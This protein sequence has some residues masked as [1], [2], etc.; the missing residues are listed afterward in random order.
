[1]HACGF[2]LRKW[3][4][5]NGCVDMFWCLLGGTKYFTL[6][7]I[8]SESIQLWMETRHKV[9]AYPFY[10]QM[11]FAFVGCTCPRD[12]SKI[13]RNVVQQVRI[14]DCVCVCVQ[15]YTIDV[16]SQ[17][18][19]RVRKGTRS[20]SV[21]V[22]EG[23]ARTDSRVFLGSYWQSGVLCT[24]KVYVYGLIGTA[25][26]CLYSSRAQEEIWNKFSADQSG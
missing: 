15:D 2:S 12:L 21:V 14:W 9:T 8:Q 6:L 25:K 18:E 23:E 19:C 22:C 20:Q 1:M 3:L 24:P 11:F 7:P 4:D 16:F 10:F 5:K 13:V 17:E 26:P